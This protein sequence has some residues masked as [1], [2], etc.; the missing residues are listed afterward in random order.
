MTNPHRLTLALVAS[1]AACGDSGGDIMN[2]DAAVGTDTPAPQDLGAPRP[3][4]VDAGVTPTVDVVDAGVTPTV[5]GGDA[6][7]ALDV[8]DAPA[9]PTDAGE[10]TLTTAEITANTTWRGIVRLPN[11]LVFVRAPAVLTVEPGTV[12]VGQASS[13]L[14]VTRGARLE[15]SGTV[16]RPIV[17]GPASAIT[18]GMTPRRGDWGGLVL[19]GGATINRTGGD[20]GAGENQIE[21]VDATDSRGRYGGG[22]DAYNCGTLRYVR[23]DYAGRV[24]ARDN[25]LNSLTLGGCGRGTT[26]DFVQTHRGEDDGIEL[27]GGTVDL[28]HIV[29]T[30][31][32]DDGLDWDY[33][34]RG[35]V[36]FLF[37]QAP[38]S[39]TESDPSGIEADNDRDANNA[40]P[41]SLPV[42][43]NATVIGPNPATNAMPGA[44]LRRGTGLRMFNALFMG[45]GARAI[46]V[47][48]TA[49]AALTM[50]TNPELQV[51]NS[52]FHNNGAMGTTHFVGDS[53]LNDDAV[54]RDAA[55]MNRFDLDPQLPAAGNL[56]APNVTPPAN[57]PAATGAATPSDAFFDA[58]ATYVG[59]VRPGATS[60]WM[61]GWTRF[62]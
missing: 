3:D 53:T 19:L 31:S 34:W 21:G 56:T 26:I 16:D 11:E 61:D 18:P 48:D 14:I 39:S 23:I 36:Q 22:D 49:S 15:A 45:W 13:A 59:A 24:L 44:V 5:D 52:L 30:Q 29:I 41:R 2:R 55:R 12:V 32:D 35:R 62:L 33:G 54:F 38:A 46:D 7:A 51:S 27:F 58:T 57:S 25:E 9:A 8:V 50:G 17:F 28:R 4:V 37:V 40:A 42:I 47:R 43:Y 1:L 60:T 6:G 10:T 20:A